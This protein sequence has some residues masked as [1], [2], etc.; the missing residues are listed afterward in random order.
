ML[1]RGD[2]G[3]R[4]F[5]NI[6]QFI[7]L[8]TLDSTLYKSR[9]EHNETYLFELVTID[10]NAERIPPSTSWCPIARIRTIAVTSHKH[11]FCGSS[12]SG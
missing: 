1:R 12:N 6:V 10:F 7:S 5:E 4:K 8:I 9:V 11:V 3:S 2:R